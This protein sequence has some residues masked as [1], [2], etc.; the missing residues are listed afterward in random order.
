[1]AARWATSSGVRQQAS[2][3]EFS[4]ASHLDHEDF[5]AQDGTIIAPHIYFYYLSLIMP[6]IHSHLN[7]LIKKVNA[8]QASVLMMFSPNFEAL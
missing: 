5:E 1:M 6:C 3:Q 2:L 8:M 4:Q 7:T